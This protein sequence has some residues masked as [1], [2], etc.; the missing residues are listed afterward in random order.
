MMEYSFIFPFAGKIF[1]LMIFPLLL[2]FQNR[3]MWILQFSKIAVKQKSWG[4]KLVLNNNCWAA[5]LFI[6][7]Y[8]EFLKIFRIVA[9][10]KIFLSKTWEQ[11]SY[12]MMF[13]Q[14]KDASSQPSMCDEFTALKREDKNWGWSSQWRSNFGTKE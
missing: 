4:W 11:K 13:D 12:T 8:E 1:A 14:L 6:C 9:V 7:F 5:K 2:R 10:L 3:V